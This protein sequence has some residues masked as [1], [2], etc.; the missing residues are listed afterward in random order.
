MPRLTNKRYQQQLMLTMAV[1]MVVLLAASSLVHAVASLPLKALLAVAPVLPMLYVIALIWRRIRDS[2]ELEQ[3]MHL[4]A[5]G[6]AAALVSA[7]S[8]VGGF[9][10]ADGVLDLG[11]SVLIWVF[12]VLMFGYGTAS[13][14][15]A[16]HYG[17][18]SMCAGEGA[19]W[20]PWY[21]LGIGVLMGLFAL[22]QWWRHDGH[23]TAAFAFTACLFV[24]M[25]AWARRRQI[26]ADRRARED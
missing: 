5:L 18:D 10:A 1:Y 7:L 9:L 20:L 13:R 16:R 4:V 2:D 6:V 3:R 22:Y 23:G 24:A 11:G 26:R 17:M 21:F 12:P 15:V 8:M 14:W 19:E 25:A